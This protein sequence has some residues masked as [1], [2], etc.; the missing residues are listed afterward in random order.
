MDILNNSFSE[1]GSLFN[2]LTS[3][4]PLFL[5]FSFGENKPNQFKEGLHSLHCEIVEIIFDSNF[6][7]SSLFLTSKTANEKFS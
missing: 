4:K 5:I 1:R 2:S 6:N 3:H 7:L